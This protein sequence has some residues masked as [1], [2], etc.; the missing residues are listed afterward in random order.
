MDFL[1]FGSDM[2]GWETIR[3][4]ASM[5]GGAPL[6]IHLGCQT[7]SGH[8]FSSSV[9][10]CFLTFLGIIALAQ[11][12]PGVVVLSGDINNTA[13]AGQP[14][15]GNIGI[16]GGGSGI[17]LGDGWVISAA[18]VAG[19]L[20][21][22]VTFGGVSYATAA[23][24]FHHI[25]NPTGSGLSTLTDIVVFRLGTNPGLPSLSIASS[26]PTVGD[27][28]T[29]IGNGRTQESTPTYWHVD[30]L[31][32]TSDDVWTE[33]SYPDPNINAEGFLTTGT[34]EIRWGENALDSV[35]ETIAYGFG[36]VRSIFTSFDLGESSQEAQAVSGDSGGAVLHH[37]G[38][39]WVLSGM[40]VAVGTLENQPG[41]S[42]SAVIGDITA[43]ADLSFYRNEILAIIPEPS[44][45]AMGIIAVLALLS[46]RRR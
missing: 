22:S 12:A 45:S 15:F 31:P 21:A 7:A 40:M 46:R 6:A 38:T 1:V 33:L 24:T 23:G 8:L 19:S 29:M 39:G 2:R 28:V 37:D 18:H 17:Y 30:T 27:S 13:P 34:K 43:S 32:G 5:T 14:Y 16:V 4:A 44:A 25:N 42:T 41:G 36:D 35:N 26:S 9:K 11:T 20:P 10:R 3:A